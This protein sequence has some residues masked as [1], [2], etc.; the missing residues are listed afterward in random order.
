MALI[1]VIKADITK[2]KADAIVNA[3][4]RTLL[5]GGG[6]DGA[7]HRA[8]GKAL[9]EECK[10]MNGCNT[11]DVKITGGYDLPAK[12]IIHAVGPVWSGGKSS[13]REL[14]ASCYR[15]ALKLAEDNL[16]SSVAFSCISTG[17]YGY[18]KKEAAETAI[19][20]VRSFM[21]NSEKIKEVIFV[22]FDD[23]NYRIYNDL[24][25]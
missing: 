7:I 1:K 10:K 19:N 24:L 17:V 12:Y 25:K 2:I 21:E 4:N 3:A 14:L 5:G 18:P 11:G 22:T 16:L 23:E 6:V 20:E 15:K 13:E 8:A 9:Y